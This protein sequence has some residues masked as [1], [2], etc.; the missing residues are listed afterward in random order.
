LI[1]RAVE[2]RQ[3]LKFVESAVREHTRRP[4]VVYRV[5]AQ[6]VIEHVPQW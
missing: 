4:D 3:V 1:G 6:H 2:H 5:A